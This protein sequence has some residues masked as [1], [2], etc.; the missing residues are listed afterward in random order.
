[1]FKEGDEFNMI[2]CK[3]EI[4]H[5]L[6]AYLGKSSDCSSGGSREQL[7]FGYSNKQLEIW[8]QGRKSIGIQFSSAA[9]S[10]HIRPWQRTSVQGRDSMS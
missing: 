9:Q 1:M 8:H 3:R 2:V 4:Q 7:T 5:G 6:I 10:C